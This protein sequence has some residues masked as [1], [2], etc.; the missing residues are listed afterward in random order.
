[1]THVFWNRAHNDPSRSSKVIDFGTN[2]RCVYDFLFDLN[3]NLGPILPRFRDIRAF[4]RQN[5]FFPHPTPFS[6]ENFGCSPW[7]R[8]V[9]LGSPESEHPRLARDSIENLA[10]R[11]IIFEEFQPMRSQSTDATDVQTDGQT[12]CDRKTALC[13][14]VH[15][16]VIKPLDWT[17]VDI[18]C[19][20]VTLQRNL[21]NFC[22]YPSSWRFLT[23][24]LKRKLTTT[25]VTT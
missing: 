12:T 21:A 8:P 23:W 18:S 3:S 6:G 5:H 2:R 7:S 16:A 9:M 19:W 15:R 4:V 24:K 10:N 13:T 14:K 25:Y 11:E 20:N 22:R 17:N 1:M